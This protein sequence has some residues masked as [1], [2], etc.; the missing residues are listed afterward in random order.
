MV[1]PWS[2]NFWHTE[3]L[4]CW[5][6]GN[7]IFLRIRSDLGF[8]SSDAICSEQTLQSL[9]LWWIDCIRNGRS[10]KIF[11]ELKRK[12]VWS[13][14]YE[15]QVWR[16]YMV[17]IINCL[18]AL[19]NTSK[20]IRSSSMK[21]TTYLNSQP[22]TSLYLIICHLSCRIS[23]HLEMLSISFRGETK[24]ANDGLTFSSWEKILLWIKSRTFRSSKSCFFSIHIG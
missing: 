17:T 8:V 11:P 21:A 22:V 3:H 16:T 15:I 9:A 10:E 12:H 24:I 2:E 18:C 1:D 6:S 19:E 14:E 4:K 7:I 5:D 13:N 23:A 20:L